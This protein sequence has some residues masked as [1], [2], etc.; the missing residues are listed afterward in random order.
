MTLSAG[1]FVAACVELW[2]GRAE[3]LAMRWPLLTVIALHTAVCAAG[4][5]DVAQGRVT[6]EMIPRISTGLG[7]IY[8]ELLIFLIA[9][10]TLIALM[11]R[12]RRENRLIAFASTDA[13][14]GLA[15]RGAFF[16]RAGRIVTRAREAKSAVSLILFDLDKFKQIND[17]YGHGAGDRV[18][19]GFAS[20]ASAALRPT[21]L[22]GR[23]GGEEF[24]AILP[25]AGSVE[26]FTIAER[27]RHAV[28][29]TPT[30]FG[31]AT[32]HA[33]VSGGIA[34]TA[35][36]ANLEALLSAADRA[37]YKAKAAGRNR[38][39]TAE[40]ADSKAA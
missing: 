30:L 26:A 18:L 40:N 31:D 34:T 21:D 23:I 5:P 32:I 10:G 39:E 28:E 38:I 16:L 14:S 25:G 12:E 4:I 8:F 36:G 24:S 15:N 20:I 6:L 11:S 7:L 37:L 29:V 17:A 22:I 3:R 9:S 2:L 33:T 35:T 13:V 27:V 1:L 19:S